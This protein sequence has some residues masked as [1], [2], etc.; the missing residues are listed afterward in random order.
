VDVTL[1]EWF[2]ERR[3]QNIPISGPISM[4]KSL[5]FAKKLGDRDFSPST[6]WLDRFKERHSI[7]CRSISGKSAVVDTDICDDW[8]KNLTSLK[9][10]TGLSQK[11][12][13]Q[14]L[15]LIRY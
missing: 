11:C 1:Y 15:P 3:N 13:K 8:L 7:V 4:A 2:K 5:K 10:G 9:I 6:G 12:E 14:F